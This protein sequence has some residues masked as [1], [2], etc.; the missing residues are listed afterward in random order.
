MKFG[1]RSSPARHSVEEGWDTMEK[2]EKLVESSVEFIARELKKALGGL[3]GK[4]HDPEAIRSIVRDQIGK[5]SASLGVR[6]DEE[7]EALSEL[8]VV[9]F[10]GMPVDFNPKAILARVSD[11]TLALL[12]ER[13]HDCAFPVNLIS[14]EWMRRTGNIKD[15]TFSRESDQTANISVVPKHHLTGH[16]TDDIVRQEEKKN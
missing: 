7:H 4:P 15:W 13:L 3:I 8:L 9:G 16:T 11:R 14:F 10:L 1:L 6:A 2:T 12:A 5:I